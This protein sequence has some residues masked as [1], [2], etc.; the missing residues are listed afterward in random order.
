M[1]A[2]FI[3]VFIMKS[4]TLN[5]SMLRKYLLDDITDDERQALEEQFFQDDSLFDEMSAL[6]DELYFDYQQNRLNPKESKAF[7]QKFLQT[8]QEI[9]KAVFANVFLE[10][11]AELATEKV[12]II[13]KEESVSW[14]K[15]F[16]AFFD[17]SGSMMQ[18]SAAAALLLL[19]FGIIGLLIQNSRLQNEMAD[20]QNKQAQERQEQERIL[21]EKEKQQAELERQQRELEQ[22]LA[23][24]KQ[25]K[26]Q[27]E[28]RIKEI[29]TERQKLDRE[30]NDT[31]RQI[32]EIPLP[33]QKR[34]NQPQQ[35][36]FA[37]LILSPGV[38]TRGEG[39]GLGKVKLTP[40]LKN[41]QLRLLLKNKEDYA[42][43]DVIVKTV[44][45]QSVVWTSSGL[46]PQGKGTNQSI[47]VMI[48]TKNL[49][50]ADYELS[51]IGITK[52]GEREEVSIYYFGAFR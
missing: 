34:Q 13:E 39:E 23:T 30:I 40:E 42:S 29:E 19:A 51:L 8:P 10:T 7:E 21:A 1:K 46:K 27:N 11:T 6:E 25:Q 47:S 33:Q 45:E 44:D 50:R 32:N 31:R 17:F 18:F 14:W 9:E 3:A 4:P 5:D 20:L 52:N 2:I 38:F 35:P 24:E 22:Q 36:S 16:V 48:P 15:S 26:E 49:Q 41:L 37:T 43:Y 28:Q 12:E